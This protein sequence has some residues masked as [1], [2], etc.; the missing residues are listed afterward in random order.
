MGTVFELSTLIFLE[1]VISKIVLDKGLTDEQMRAV[2]A[3]LE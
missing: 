2:H 3:N 1:A